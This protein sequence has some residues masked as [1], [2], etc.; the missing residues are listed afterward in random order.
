VNGLDCC[1]PHHDNAGQRAT[2][3]RLDAET[4]MAG[5]YDSTVPAGGRGVPPDGTGAPRINAGRL[6]AGGLATAVVAALIALVGVLIVRA[7]FRVALFAPK[8]AG[9]FGDSDTVLLCV[10]AAV[11]ALAATGLVHLLLLST[12]RPLAYFGWIVG[13]LTAVAVVL[14][15]LGSGPLA[16]SLATAV[17]HLVIGLA[18]GS[19]VSGAA[20]SATRRPRPVPPAYGAQ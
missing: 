6:W 12:P 18:I 15:F 10:W 17:I 8:E 13:L 20:A 3:D 9:A 19:L 14:P 1:D 5:Y 4:E 11:A 2:H 16:V 7:V